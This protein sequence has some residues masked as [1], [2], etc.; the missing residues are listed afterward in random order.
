MVELTLVRLIVAVPVVLL[1]RGTSVGERVT[2][3]SDSGLVVQATV[4]MNNAA[5]ATTLASITS[6]ERIVGE[7]G[8][9]RRLASGRSVGGRM[10]ILAEE[11][12]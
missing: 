4:G 3:S 7:G 5:P 9:R 11:M 12:V 8:R 2:E 10:M 6:A 1:P